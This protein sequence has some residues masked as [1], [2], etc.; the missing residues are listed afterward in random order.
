MVMATQDGAEPSKT[1]LHFSFYLL[2]AGKTSCV[3]DNGFIDMN[4][5]T[6]MGL[7]KSDPPKGIT[8][9]TRRR[10]I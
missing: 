1:T 9:E 3:V 7:P 6:K 10:E 8:A 4:L 2:E 5:G